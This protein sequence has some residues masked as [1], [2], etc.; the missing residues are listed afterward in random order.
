MP[1]GRNLRFALSEMLVSCPVLVQKVFDFG[2]CSFAG[3]CRSPFL[4][5]WLFLVPSLTCTIE[6]I[7]IK[8]GTTA[9]L[10]RAALSP[11]DVVNSTWND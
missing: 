2:I 1:R 10:P 7:V 8:F 11:E 6:L 5:N 3:T 9:G 4:Q